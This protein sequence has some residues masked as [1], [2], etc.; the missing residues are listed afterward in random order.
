M[1]TAIYRTKPK[2]T[3]VST[4]DGAEIHSVIKRHRETNHIVSVLT[5]TGDIKSETELLFGRFVF[6]LDN[7]HAKKVVFGNIGDGLK[8]MLA[9][10]ARERDLEVETAP[11]HP[12]GENLLRET[13]V[14]SC[15][16]GDKTVA[17]IDRC[18]KEGQAPRVITIEGGAAYAS[19][20]NP[21][22][23]IHSKLLSK[24]V[25]AACEDK[26]IRTFRLGGHH[27][28][29]H[30]LL[31]GRF[32]ENEE[33]EAHRRVIMGAEGKWIEDGTIPPG[34]KVERFYLAECG[35]GLMPL[36]AECC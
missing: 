27:N 7:H 10:I 8:A 11:V 6:S 33:R 9:R 17:M 22:S 16:D 31:A 25:R 35:A 36:D 21:A 4:E 24:R 12:E 13:A 20:G 23:G 32:F 1:G 26:K 2:L 18:V 14:L 3:V 15:I 5:V 34:V 28:C 29:L 30:P 19:D